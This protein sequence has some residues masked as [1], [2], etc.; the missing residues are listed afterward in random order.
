[1]LYNP[2]QRIIAMEEAPKFY[3]HEQLAALETFLP[4]LRPYLPHSNPLYHRLQAPHNIPSRHCLFAATFPPPSPSSPHTTSDVYTILFA[5]RSRHEES[6]I[7]LFNPLITQPLPLSPTHQA[8]LTA[9]LTSAMFFL[10]HHSIP[11]APG[12][13]FS[14]VLRFACVHAAV[15]LSLHHITTPSNAMP[16]RTNWQT[17]IIRTSSIPPPPP[18]PEGFTL[19][20]VP[21]DQL[22]VVLATSSIPRQPST[23]LLLPS[24][25]VR[26]AAGALVAWAYVGIDGGLATLYVLPEYRGRGFA[27]VVAERVLRGLD[28]GEFKDL[29]F[30]G[31]GW[32]LADVKEGND[33]SEGVM[34]KLGGRVEWESSYLWVDSEKL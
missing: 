2:N 6:Q 34:R 33:G 24:A 20:R 27:V 17:W 19:I 30:G 7:W 1:L 13:P 31:S 25:G 23:Y 8:T 10:K 22:A 12:W 29:G 3:A 28:G 14:P 9:H 18:L 32:V 15:A 21:A 4:L 16:Y 11:Q 26:D 5:D